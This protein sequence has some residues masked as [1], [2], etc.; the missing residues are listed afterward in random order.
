MSIEIIKR[1]RGNRGDQAEKTIARILILIFS[2][3]F[4]LMMCN[5]VCMRVLTV[6]AW[7]NDYV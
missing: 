4:G 6:K 3:F 2:L 1:E 7:F 5:D